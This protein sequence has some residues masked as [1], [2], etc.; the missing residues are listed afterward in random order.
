MRRTLIPKGDQKLTIKV[1]GAKGNLK[2]FLAD[3]VTYDFYPSEE[4]PVKVAV[5]WEIPPLPIAKNT[6]VGKIRVTDEKGLTLQ[7]RPLLAQE[8]L[9]PTLWQKF[10]TLLAHNK[11]GR[12]LAF[13]TGATLVF[14]FL[15]N[16]RKKK[17]RRR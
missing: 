8:P 2:T 13:G 16:T 11:L 17:Y 9:N 10:K 3:H 6:P 4:I 7:E 14:F 5:S 1:R 15:W 12:K